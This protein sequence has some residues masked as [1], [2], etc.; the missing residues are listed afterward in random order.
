LLVTG[1]R[2]AAKNQLRA[3]LAT[4]RR[5]RQAYVV[6]QCHTVMGVLA[7]VLGEYRSMALLAETARKEAEQQDWQQTVGAA[8]ARLLLGYRALLVSD[9]T[10]C[11]RQVGEADWLVDTD[12]PAVNQSLPLLKST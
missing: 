10:E 6:F 1:R 5:R 8:T 7:G 2:A 11:L 4:A 9:P 12:D 3:A